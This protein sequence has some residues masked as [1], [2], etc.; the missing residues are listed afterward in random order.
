MIFSSVVVDSY[1]VP[2]AA[3]AWPARHGET[4]YFHVDYGQICQ[5]LGVPKLK[6]IL[7]VPKLLLPMTYQL[8]A[9]RMLFPSNQGTLVSCDRFI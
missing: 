9:N 6:S 1:Q 5:R 2:W 4:R 3:E 7:K 8:K